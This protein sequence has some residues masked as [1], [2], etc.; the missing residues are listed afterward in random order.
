MHKRHIIRAIVVL[1]SL[2]LIHHG[3]CVVSVVSA[4]LFLLRFCDRLLNHALLIYSLV[5]GKSKYRSMNLSKDTVLY[6]K[7]QYHPNVVQLTLLLQILFREGWYSSNTTLMRQQHV[8][9][10]GGT[11]QYTLKIKLRSKY[12]FAANSYFFAATK[13]G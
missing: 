11:C 2:L 13:Y 3:V 9:P 1:I 6:A 7:V 10:A 4:S 5:L 12:F 8:P